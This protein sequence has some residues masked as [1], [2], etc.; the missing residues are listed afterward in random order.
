MAEYLEKILKELNISNIQDFNKL[1]NSESSSSSLRIINS[2][3]AE[4]TIGIEYNR[5]EGRIFK[6]KIEFKECIIDLPNL[7]LRDSGEI[8]FIDCIFTGRVLIGAADMKSILIDSCIFLDE[9]IIGMAGIKSE[10]CIYKANFAKLVF[11]SLEAFSIY[12][13]DC[14]ID[15][16]EIVESKINEMRTVSNSISQINVSQTYFRKIYFPHAQIDFNAFKGTSRWRYFSKK[17]SLS[18][19]KNLETV[20]HSN[21]FLFVNVTTD[22]FVDDIIFRREKDTLDFISNCTDIKNNRENYS[23]IVMN[24]SIYSQSNSVAKIFMYLFGSF[25]KPKLI[26][27][28]AALVYVLFAAI[29]STMPLTFKIGDSVSC[30]S[31]INALYFSG[32]TFTTIGYGDIVPVG[33]AKYL[34]VIEGGLGIFLSSSFLVSLIRKYCD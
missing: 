5:E 31:F 17:A 13:A 22:E 6:D 7:N 12:L 8:N 27:M 18:H 29:Y 11:E 2:N 33:F 32:I 28:Y 24:S 9:V 23:E 3:N 26:L 4:S 14:R 30:I 20:P 21:L 19:K 16:F 15:I 25:V 34:S 10:I 1:L